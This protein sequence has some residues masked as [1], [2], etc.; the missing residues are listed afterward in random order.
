MGNFHLLSA[1]SNY[2]ADGVHLQQEVLHPQ[3]MG[4]RQSLP[5]PPPNTER[6][7][8]KKKKDLNKLF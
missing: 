8:F 4:Q 5:H 2:L 7:S 6:D 1:T 3:L